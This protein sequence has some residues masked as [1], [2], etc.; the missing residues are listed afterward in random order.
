MVKK[1]WNNNLEKIWLTV[2]LGNKKAIKL[3]K[4]LGF[5][6]EGIFLNDE[7]ENGK[8]QTI[9]SMAIFKN[10]KFSFKDRLKIWKNID[11][12]IE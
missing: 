9:I 5:N 4:S 6:I 3:Y 11:E 1:G 7:E 12:N 8:Y 10:K 2:Q